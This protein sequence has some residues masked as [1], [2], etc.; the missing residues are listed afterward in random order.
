M[1]FAIKTASN[2]VYPDDMYVFDGTADK[3]V[4]EVYAWT[5]SESKLV[6]PV[7]RYAPGTTIGLNDNSQVIGCDTVVF[8]PN[9][10]YNESSGGTTYDSSV[11]DFKT[12]DLDAL[13]INGHTHAPSYV[14]EA[15]LNKWSNKNYGT[16]L[17]FSASYLRSPHWFDSTTYTMNTHADITRAAYMNE[18][19]TVYLN[20]NNWTDWRLS[21]AEPGQ[22]YQPWDYASQGTTPL[23]MSTADS[24]VVTGYASG[25]RMEAA[26]NGLS[27]R[28]SSMATLGIMGWSFYLET[29]IGSGYVPLAWSDMEVLD[30]TFVFSLSAYYRTDE[31]DPVKAGS[32]GYYMDELL[33][34]GLPIETFPQGLA[35]SVWSHAV[36]YTPST[37]N[38]QAIEPII[39]GGTL[40]WAFDTSISFIRYRQPDGTAHKIRMDNMYGKIY[41]VGTAEAQW[42]TS[43]RTASSGPLTKE[44]G[45]MIQYCPWQN[46]SGTA[47]AYEDRT[48]FSPEYTQFLLNM[49]RPQHSSDPGSS[50]PT[51]QDGG[52]DYLR[53]NFRVADHL[54]AK[55]VTG[56][57]RKIQ[58]QQGAI[59]YPGEI[60]VVIRKPIAESRILWQEIGCI[61]G[62]DNSDQYLASNRY[63]RF[64][65]CTP[66]TITSSF[67]SGNESFTRARPTDLPRFDEDGLLQFSMK[68]YNCT[69]G[70]FRNYDGDFQNDF[71][72]KSDY[73]E[74]R[75][76]NNTTGK[77][78]RSY[79]WGDYCPNMLN[80]ESYMH[81]GNS[82]IAY[83]TYSLLRPYFLFFTEENSL[84][85]EV[86]TWRDFFSPG[87]N[88]DF[89]L[90]AR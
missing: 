8:K 74:M 80:H 27:S 33:L 78:F 52:Y 6:W 26:T 79:A 68:D 30:A 4:A 35:S 14:N 24:H 81:G 72:D 38:W 71:F 57:E 19:D 64:D 43:T 13:G 70:D 86:A 42:G 41:D 22:G 47:L 48:L 17:S 32:L 73:L 23:L 25:D 51:A 16:A 83:S 18:V 2:W 28:T 84:T 55:Y 31:T 54:D 65:D 75:V 85:G 5:G 58:R 36:E 61:V 50:Y 90:Y 11:E 82:A 29:G 62:T 76:Y 89:K 20:P 15:P 53:K 87:D 12:M 7:P 77:W 44:G 63:A 21:I 9:Y 34:G 56:G 45:W 3:V 88:I 1:E 40:P 46:E 49:S 60:E 39:D 37:A 67:P 66:G 59:F 69:N 10:V